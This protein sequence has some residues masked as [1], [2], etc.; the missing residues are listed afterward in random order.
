M[1]GRALKNRRHVTTAAEFQEGF[2]KARGG[3]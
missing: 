1:V 2:K 3:K